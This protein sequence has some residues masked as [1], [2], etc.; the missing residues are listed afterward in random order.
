LHIIT[1]LQRNLG[2]ELQQQQKL[3]QLLGK[4]ADSPEKAVPEPIQERT[5]MNE[6]TE[7]APA[8]SSDK[9]WASPDE[10][11]AA[12]N[13]LV[14]HLLVNLPGLSAATRALSLTGAS[15]KSDAHEAS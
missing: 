9:V 15:Y 14:Q 13:D 3:F 10:R 1:R 7:S 5:T 4:P 2:I 8:H 6:L 12:I 11:E